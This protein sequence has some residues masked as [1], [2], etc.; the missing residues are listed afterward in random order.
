MKYPKV[1][2][3]NIDPRY[4]VKVAVYRHVTT[5]NEI[6]VVIQ[7]IQSAP[8]LPMVDDP[9]GVAKVLKGGGP[10]VTFNVGK[11]YPYEK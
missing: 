5:P 3:T 6:H 10:M 9:E 11:T 1:N 7:S 4:E 8:P 2:V